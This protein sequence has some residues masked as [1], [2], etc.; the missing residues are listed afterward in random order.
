MS[1]ET[2]AFQRQLVNLPILMQCP[3]TDARQRFFVKPLNLAGNVHF[4]KQVRLI[5]R[6]VIFVNI[7]VC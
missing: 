4:S 5:P 7:E 6:D 1:R 3:A 2:A